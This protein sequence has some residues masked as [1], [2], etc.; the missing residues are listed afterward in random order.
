[1]KGIAQ[2]VSCKID[3]HA[4]VIDWSI[5]KHKLQGSIDVK[6]SICATK[7][8]KLCNPNHP[9]KLQRMKGFNITFKYDNR[10]QYLMKTSLITYFHS[11]TKS[12]D[13]IA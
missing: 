5:F 13:A 2:Q 11:S 3:D 4:S 12:N 1:M 7:G 6:F 10:E 8:L 9:E